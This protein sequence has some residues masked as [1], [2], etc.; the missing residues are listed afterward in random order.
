VAKG[1]NQIGKPAGILK[2][3]LANPQ[4]ITLVQRRIC[5]KKLTENLEF[6]CAVFDGAL[7]AFIRK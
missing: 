1:R 5:N 7:A 2:I 3:S 6:F 4:S